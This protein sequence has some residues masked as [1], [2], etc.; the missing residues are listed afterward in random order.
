MKYQYW[1]NDKK[2]ATLEAWIESAEEHPGSWW[3]HYADWLARQ[4]G[5]Q[6]VG[7]HA[8]RHASASSRTPR[9]AT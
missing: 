1:T 6:G 9:A 7:A 4:S 5:G 8:G 2:A 3:P